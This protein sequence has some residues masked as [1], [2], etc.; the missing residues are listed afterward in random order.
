MVDF[1]HSLEEV[2]ESRGRNMRGLP[3]RGDFMAS[4]NSGQGL[5]KVFDDEDEIAH[6]V[7][8]GRIRPYSGLHS[9]N[10]S[11]NNRKEAPFKPPNDEEVFKTRVQEKNMRHQEKEMN[12]RK[13]IWEKNTATTRAPLQR[14]RTGDISPTKS[15]EN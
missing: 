2:E 11:I 1:L 5:S 6:I 9:R 4:R 7:Q 10:G 8:P 13:R 12:M 15:V 3:P 14:V